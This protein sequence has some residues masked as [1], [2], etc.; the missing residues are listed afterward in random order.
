[1]DYG[2]WKR[3]LDFLKQYVDWLVA[4]MRHSLVITCSWLIAERELLATDHSSGS[5]N[6]CGTV[7]AGSANVIK[8][9]QLVLYSHSFKC[10]QVLTHTVLQPCYTKVLTT[11]MLSAWCCQTLSHALLLL[12]QMARHNLNCHLKYSENQSNPVSMMGGD[13]IQIGSS[14]GQ[15]G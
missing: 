5:K 14:A 10:P 7:E 9:D 15:K 3:P 1:M 2:L 11:L 6:L 8:W 4:T 12:S 13:Q